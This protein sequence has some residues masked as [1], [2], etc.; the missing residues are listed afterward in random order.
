MEKINKISTKIIISAVLITVFSVIT[1]GGIFTFNL[2][3][4]SNDNL[5]AIN[6]VLNDDYDVLIKSEVEGAVSILQHVYSRYEKGEITLEEAKKLGADTLR[7]M[8]Y[9]ENGYF[10][11]DTLEGENVVLLGNET[12][13]TNR[14]E[15]QDVN[16]KYVIK[17]FIKIA[18]E[19]G[20]YLDYSFPKPGEQEA[21]LKR[22]Y[23]YLFE[24]FQWEI[25]TGN[26]IDNI[27]VIS[28][29]FK[30]E[31][32][33]LMKDLLITVILT[34]LAVIALGTIAAYLTGK[35]ISRPIV[36]LTAVAE[37]LAVGDTN[38]KLI[39]TSQ[40]EVGV[41]TDAFEKIVDN[42]REQS[43]HARKISEGDLSIDIIPKSEADILSQSMSKVVLELKS[44]VTEAEILTRGAAEGNLSLRGNTERF[45][46]GYQDI[47]SG[48]NHTL[49]AIVEPLNIALGFIEH[50]ANGDELTE[51][52]NLYK[53]D[54]GVLINHLNMVRES[55]NTLLSE[56]EKLTSAAADGDLSYRA[57]VSMLKGSYSR[58]V[59][60]VN[61]ALDSVVNP[62][63]VA[64]SCMDRIGRGEIPERITEVYYGD[65][66][67][68]KNSINSCIDGLGG[69]AEGRD[70]LGAMKYNDFT[71][72]VEGVHQGIYAEIAESV[73]MVSERINTIIDALNNIAAGD[74][75]Q[76]PEFKKIGKRSENDTLMPAIII[77]L[78]NINALVEETSML[79]F[80]AIEGKLDT[81]G[82]SGKFKGEYSRV[83]DGIN[84]TLN[85]VIAPV[86]EALAVLTE[87]SHGN[88]SSS[89]R[90][91]YKGD[92]AVLKNTLN[93]TIHIIQSYV[94]EISGVLTQM[95]DGNLN[96]SIT[97]DYR[98]DF[99]EIKNSLNHILTTLSEVMGDINE[100]AEQVASGSRQ[101][102]DGSQTLSQGST[103]QASS[104][105]EL[106]ASIAEIASQTRQNAIDASEANELAG[107][108]RN[109]AVKGNEQMRSML[110]SMVEISD[111]SASIS[112]IIKV[113]DDIAFQTN[114]LALNAA[115]EAARAGQHGKGF[116][117]VA[118]EVRNLAARSAEAAR[119]TTG[120]IEGSIHKVQAGTKIA[121]DTAAALVEIV[122]GIEKAAGIVE[123][124]ASA[125]NE[126]ASG[127]AQINKG[128]EQ[129][130]MVVQ[131][132]SATAEE[133]AAASEELSSQA[134]LLKQMMGRF[135]LRKELRSNF[136]MQRL[137]EIDRNSE[138]VLSSEQR[139]SLDESGYDK[140]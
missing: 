125:S 81:R 109:N 84:A 100:A 31:N 29:G 124:I 60:G 111:S 114:I 30:A 106:T 63:Q 11:A 120:L 54:Y 89:V 32:Q 80:A 65:F 56:T 119:E 75:K 8:K 64:A 23:A 85:A 138:T 25:G 68:I 46:G 92:H 20:G 24:P 88:L 98:G 2:M 34:A 78:E 103:E 127:I 38:V 123:N 19:G 10:W 12:E 13:G 66:D 115:V 128:I 4:Q 43:E 96:L 69:L 51:L 107:A 67:D 1:V 49:D 90:G 62:L 37:K 79:S 110:K 132:N 45:K 126:Q 137:A 72:K 21:S 93:E 140:Y 5:L 35:R 44:L 33:R 77:M 18:K 117:V 58:I 17:E 3:K 121:D 133:S 118:E 97:A 99:I 28:D 134:E 105:E 48:F 39:R 40:D 50:M 36:A 82:D 53:G 14:I 135:Q 73:N 74:L 113:I 87:I 108:A 94:S 95:A 26:Y 41:L 9:G 104:I 16:G 55:L 83:I 47:I 130:S 7:D 102:S 129:V 22:G 70:V 101:V 76:L 15:F 122:E 27:Q 57:D 116:A 59:G 6:K 139:I 71:R 112:R 91:D 86:D 52:E 61:G 136:G 42:I 131:N